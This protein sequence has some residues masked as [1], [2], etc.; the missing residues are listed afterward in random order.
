MRQEKQY[1]LIFMDVR[2]PG[3]D[4]Y[5]TSLRIRE[6]EEK[7]NVSSCPII[8]ISAD[9][10]KQDV[11]KSISHGVCDYI[12]K[13]VKRDKILQ[14]VYKYWYQKSTY[15]YP[16]MNCKEKSKLQSGDRVGCSISK[17]RILT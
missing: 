5:Q 10:F 15:G 16:C 4:G 14:T 11:E 13:P 9:A 1:D 17:V 6:W 3:I 12:P 8:M 7:A 2:M